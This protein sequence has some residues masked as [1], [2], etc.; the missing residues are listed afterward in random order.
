MSIFRA[1]GGA[2]KATMLAMVDQA[3]VSASNLA[4]SAFLIHYASRS[5]YGLYGIGYAGLALLT[6]LPV[7]AIISQMTVLAPHES[8]ATRLAFCSALQLALFVACG[9]FGILIVVAGLI[10]WRFNIVPPEE[11]RIIIV[12]GAGAIGFIG[13]EFQKAL[14]YLNGRPQTVLMLSA[15]QTIVWAVTVALALW[16]ET[17]DLSAWVLA[18]C[19]GGAGFAIFVRRTIFPMPSSG[20]LRSAWIAASRAWT[21]GSWSLLGTIVT[22]VQNQGYAWVLPLLI[23][24][25]SVGEMNFAKLFFA[26]IPLLLAAVGRVATPRLAM[27]FATE[28]KRSAVI[29]GR[30]LLLLVVVVLVAYFAAVLVTKDWIIAH[31]AKRGYENAGI[32]IIAWGVVAAIQVSR[33][34]STVLLVVFRRNRQMTGWSALSAVVATV[35]SVALAPSQGVIGALIGMAAGEAILTGL[36]WRTVSKVASEEPEPSRNPA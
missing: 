32:L 12:V 9:F 1:G 20:G 7:G 2:T 16:S 31:Y 26:P 30:R 36:L 23:G 33:W 19:C 3:L 15:S 18:G 4:A 11:A 27:V 35:L 10:I 8:D 5:E 25:A 29:H 14:L 21:Q 34:N 22:W 6:G 28:S 24:V 13:L 17:T